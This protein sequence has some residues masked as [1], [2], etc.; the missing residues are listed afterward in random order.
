[1]VTISY[2]GPAIFFL[3]AE[4]ARQQ[5]LFRDQGLEAKL[6][7]TKSDADRAA[8][9]SGD[10]DYTL[11]GG[12]TVL[13]AARG[14]PVR[15]LFVGTMKPFWALV[16]RPE[17]NSVKELKGKVM[18]VAGLAGA[19]HLT[20]KAIL[21]Q[22]GLDPDKDVVLKVVSVG[23]RIPALMSGAMDA[24]LIDYSEAFRAKRSGFK[25]LLNAAD[26][27]SVLSSAVGANL[28]KLR[29]QPEQ[30]KRF[31]KAT[32]LAHKFMRERREAS[33][34][35]LMN[36]IKADRETAQE[37]YQLSIENFTRDGM[38]DESLLKAVIDQQLTESKVAPVPLS[39]VVDFSL[40]QQVLKEQR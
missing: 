37:I 36:W 20:T 12:S 28:K 15:M 31:L 16:V 23:A 17:V 2:P 19:H 7:L 26:H 29:E 5:G 38:G 24:G 33:L 35:I 4:I 1:V 10:V 22:H 11:R 9:A 3:P 6:V 8:L 32:V 25:I 39:Q 27:Y 34:T 14:L 21:K 13:S 40:L 18:G 30:V